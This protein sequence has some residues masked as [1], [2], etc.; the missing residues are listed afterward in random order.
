MVR[1]VDQFDPE[2]VNLAL[3]YRYLLAVGGISLACGIVFGLRLNIAAILVL[4]VVFG[5]LAFFV[6]L[7]MGSPFVTS[8]ILAAVALV[9]L[10]IG[11]IVGIVVRPRTREASSREDVSPQKSNSR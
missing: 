11:Y 5:G 1:L 2:A 7:G 3:S 10:Q 6:T 8:I 4:S 9:F